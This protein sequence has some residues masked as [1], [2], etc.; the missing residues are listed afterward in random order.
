MP[1]VLTTFL[2]HSDSIVKTLLRM[3]SWASSKNFMPRKLLTFGR[4][5][6]A[7]FLV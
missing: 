3:K 6:N 7:M 2:W 4:S 5:L 1:L